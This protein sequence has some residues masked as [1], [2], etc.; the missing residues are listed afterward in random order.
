MKQLNKAHT[1]P[2]AKL[3]PQK[4]NYHKTQYLDNYHWLK[5]KSN[6]DVLSYLESEN[7]YTE[8]MMQDTDGLQKKL[9][10]E[11]LS[12]IKEVDSSVPEKIDN[13]YYYSRTEEGKAYKIYCRKKD[14]LDSIEEVLLDSNIL[15]KEHKFFNLGVFEVS[16]NHKY[17]A[18]SVDT[19]GS[20]IYTIYIKEIAK[21]KLLRETIQ[22]TSYSLVWT[23]DSN[24]FF[25][26]TLDDSLR[27]YKAYRH[28]LTTDGR[29]DE[30]ILH[31]KDD[32][33]YIDIYKTNSKAFIMFSSESQITSEIRYLNANNYL[34]DLRLFSTRKYN[35]QYFLEH[36][37]DNF[38]IKTNENAQNFKLLKTPITN[39]SK[40]N[41]KDVIPHRELVRLDD[42]LVFKNYL[43]AFER[44][45]GLQQIRIENINTNNVHYIDFSEPVYALS[46]YGNDVFE[47]NLLRFEYTSLVTPDSIFDYNMENKT[48]EL[49]KQKE[50]VGYYY[51]DQYKSERVFAKAEDGTSIPISLVYKEELFKNDGTNPLYLYGYGS[52][53]ICIDPEFS[54]NILSLLDRGF[55]YAIAH[56]RGGGEMG[57]QWY[58]NGKFLKKKNTFTDFVN[59]AEYLVNNKYT[60]KEKLVISGGSAGGLL[61]G[62]VTNLRPDLFKIVISKVPF[63]DVINTMM[64]PSLPLTVIEYDE[65][66]NPNDK[67]YFEY[68]KSYSPYDNIEEKE[69]PNMLVVAGLNDPRVG[70]WEP[71]KYVAKL[72]TMKKDDNVILLKTNMG[73]GH[74]GASGRYDYLKDVAFEYSFIFE[75]LD[76]KED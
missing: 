31:E 24:A 22:N 55:V 72:R 68:M 30:L 28:K 29:N 25:Y 27:P 56:I 73:F 7:Q 76:I 75:I 50:V 26:T 64:D 59:C 32:A 62:A 61:M 9:Y 42:I 54:P 71:A 19:S 1:Y 70:Y 8:K 35:V 13:Y 11:L 49:K 15:A 33:F 18:Y 17:L 23:N 63:V 6:Q 52:Y 65:W 48:K 10:K 67:T 58:E 37:S 40:E 5:D 66:G 69:Y 4:L 44:K 39:I 2:I 51:P 16:P 45:D 20:E 53:E 3:I 60:S 74:K 41:W 14:S 21:D 43:V 57:R 38:Y 12:R 34:E 36:H 47:T 46:I